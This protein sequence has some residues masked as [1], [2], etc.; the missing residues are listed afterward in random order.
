MISVHLKVAGVADHGLVL[1]RQLLPLLDEL[2]P[3][4]FHGSTSIWTSAAVVL[5][6]AGH[7]WIV[8]MRLHLFGCDQSLLDSK[9]RADKLVP[10]LNGRLGS[11]SGSRS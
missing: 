7:L 6:L 1:E 11:N 8:G 2:S 9:W 4:T 3:L 5:S 10:L